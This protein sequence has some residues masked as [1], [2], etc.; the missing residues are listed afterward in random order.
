MAELFIIS[1]MMIGFGAF[2]AVYAAVMIAYY[3]LILKSKKSIMQIMS[4]I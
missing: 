1:L 3:K 4:E 2:C